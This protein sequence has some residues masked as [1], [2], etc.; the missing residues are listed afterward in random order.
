ML[1]K[2]TSIFS[3]VIALFTKDKF[4]HAAISLDKNLD[5]L[6]S[7]GR[8]KVF[9]PFL[10]GFTE[11][12]I[13]Y[14]VYTFSPYV[15]CVVIELDVTKEQYESVK[16]DLEHFVKNKENFSYNYW[17][18]YNHLFS[19]HI[20]AKD[21]FA[22]S[23]FVYYILYKNNILDFNIPISAV[24][25]QTFL[26]RLH[27]KIIYKGNLHRYRSFLYSIDKSLINNA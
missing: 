19:S 20:R 12:K 4:T 17:A 26:D 18:I 14:G 9:N 27:D 15:P 11:E 1:T 3:R 5:V 7:F 2:T 22:C 25:P 21:S 23:E 24:R 16:K 13:N 8:K 6:Y 10:G